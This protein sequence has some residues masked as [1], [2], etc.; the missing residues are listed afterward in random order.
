MTKM[1]ALTNMTLV[2]SEEKV[3][4]QAPIE[5]IDIA[6]WLLHLP[7]SEYQ[8][9][10]PGEHLAAGATVTDDGQPMSINVE[11][12]G[13]TLLIQHY[14]AEVHEPHHCRMVS[15]TDAQTPLGW[16]KIQVIWDLSV[17]AA[18]D[19]TV[20]YSNVVLS[21]PTQ[22][23]LEVIGQSGQ[24]FQEAAA[25]RQA[26]TQAHNRVESQHYAASIAQSALNGDI[27]RAK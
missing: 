13:G 21:Y 3:V 16:T 27:S 10:A 8:R 12:I 1:E 15:M 25:Q 9:C 19:G 7:D 23:F 24:T 18:P 20:T 14:V 5:R 2:S 4:L 22:H 26:A 17:A 6:D 11:Q